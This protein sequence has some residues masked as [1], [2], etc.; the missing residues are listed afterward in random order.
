MNMLT[1]KV[2]TRFFSCP[3]RMHTT[4]EESCK[5]VLLSFKAMT[6]SARGNKGKEH[7]DWG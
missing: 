6:A 4:K 7:G 2:V 1:V 3:Y 5:P